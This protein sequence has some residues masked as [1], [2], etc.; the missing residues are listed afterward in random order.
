M[1]HLP[2][3]GQSYKPQKRRIVLSCEGEVTEPEYF[4]CLNSMSKK[5]VFEIVDNDGTGSDPDHVLS[6]MK[7]HLRSNSLLDDDEAWLVM[8]QDDWSEKKIIGLHEWEHENPN[9]HLAISRRRFEDWLK[10]HVVG[11]KDAQKRYKD[12]LLGNNKHVPS[13][14]IIKE[15]VLKAAQLARKQLNVGNVYQIIESF[16][17]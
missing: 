2:L 4:T 9:H 8:D 3:R 7:R 15:R 14:F 6:R 11:E 10:L 16:F 13:D 5:A 12:F 1:S 17:S